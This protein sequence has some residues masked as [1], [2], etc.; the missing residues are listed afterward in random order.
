MNSIAIQNCSASFSDSFSLRDIC[1]TIEPDQHWA[2]L[3]PNG[4]G[5]SAIAALLAGFGELKTGGIEGLPKRVSLVSFESQRE[6]I[7]RELDRDESDITDEVFEVLGV[8]NSV[9]SRVSYGGTAPA[10]V[11]AQIARWEVALG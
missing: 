1:L 2:I 8:E 5:K 3:G 6:L 10:Q 4:S 9:A 7:E 11:R